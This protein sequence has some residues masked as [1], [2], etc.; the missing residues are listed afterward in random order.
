VIISKLENMKPKITL[1][2]SVLILLGL[3]VPSI[4]A[5]QITKVAP[6]PHTTYHKGDPYTTIYSPSEIAPPNGTKPP[7]ITITAPIN[8]TLIASN[9]LTITFN[10][11]LESPN[12]YYPIILQGLCY[13]PSW[14]SDNI[15]IDFGSNNKVY[16]NTLPFSI[17]FT[18][19]TDGTKSIII[20]ASTM[21]E[22]ETAREEKTVA[23]GSGIFAYN[24]LYVY[25]NYYFIEDSSSV[26]FSIDTFTKTSPSPIFGLDNSR[27]T[28]LY[29][30]GTTILVISAIA[31]TAIV[32]FKKRLRK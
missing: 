19:I 9:N 20:Y 25:S 32:Y 17:S 6:T 8:N 10:L 24:Y 27:G 4:S 22:F 30:I 13:K 11:T 28:F 3:L 23:S 31:L 26:D 7:I 16:N 2:I 1:L 18:N 5:T 12:I 21:Y 14:Q 29:V 15:T